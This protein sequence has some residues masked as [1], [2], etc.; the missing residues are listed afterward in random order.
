MKSSPLRVNGIPTIDALQFEIQRVKIWLQSLSLLSYKQEKY[1]Q[2][3]RVQK[4]LLKKASQ[5]ILKMF[6]LL[7]GS[8]IILPLKRVKEFPPSSHFDLSKDEVVFDSSFEASLTSSCNHTLVQLQSC[9]NHTSHSHSSLS[10]SHI[11]FII[12]FLLR[13]EFFV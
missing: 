6:F 11:P 10:L 12:S 9:H 5:A 3:K 2:Q 7:R 8:H 13:I 4:F 1:G